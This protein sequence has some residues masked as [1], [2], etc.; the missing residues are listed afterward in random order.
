[1]LS[2]EITHGFD[3]LLA[4]FGS[5]ICTSNPNPPLEMDCV[6]TLPS[7][8]FL[9]GVSQTLQQHHHEGIISSS[10]T[11][12]SSCVLFLHEQNLFLEEPEACA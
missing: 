9:V 1:M 8:P 12:S 7:R 5:K 10:Q 11:H 3:Y 6:M 2:P 4:V